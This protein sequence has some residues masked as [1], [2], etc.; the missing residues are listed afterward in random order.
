MTVVSDRGPRHSLGS[1]SGVPDPCLG[2]TVPV[3][4]SG[5][6]DTR[7]NGIY[8]LGTTGTTGTDRWFITPSRE[9]ARLA[10]DRDIDGH[11]E[12]SVQSV[13][14]NLPQHRSQW[15]FPGGS[16]GFV[17]CRRALA[18]EPRKC[19]CCRTICSSGDPTGSA[20]DQE[21]LR[22][23]AGRMDPWLVSS[24]EAVK[25]LDE[26]PDDRPDFHSPRGCGDVLGSSGM[27][28][29]SGPFTVP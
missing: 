14:I 28:C 17:G 10:G 19:A 3:K 5:H 22:Q 4:I 9:A 2:R 18:N 12:L 24:G 13:G 27:F 16:C 29:P 25:A 15:F 26:S 8:T 6:Q 23:R 20:S 1:P 11:G 7:N 21:S